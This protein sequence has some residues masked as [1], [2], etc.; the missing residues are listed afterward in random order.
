[1]YTRFKI[2]INLKKDLPE[3]IMNSLIK[4]TNK[5]VFHD[6]DGKDWGGCL[7]HFQ[8]EVVDIPKIDHPFWKCPRISFIRLEFLKNDQ[9]KGNFIKSDEAHS[10]LKIEAELKNYNDEVYK[11]LDFIHPYVFYEENKIL[12]HFDNDYGSKGEITYTKNCFKIRGIDMY[13]YHFEETPG[14]RMDN[15]QI[16][17][18][19]ISK[20][21]EYHLETEV[22]AVFFAELMNEYKLTDKQIISALNEGLCEWD[23]EQIKIGER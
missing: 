6:K 19:F 22:L 8:K 4:L 10:I 23:L 13:G 21:K 14:G 18:A 11:F 20:F 7:D 9:I 16:S 12:G 5:E 15:L 2:Y 17:M 1:M 3:E